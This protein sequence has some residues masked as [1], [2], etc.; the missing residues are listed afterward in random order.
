ML[1][2]APAP[3]VWLLVSSQSLSQAHLTGLTSEPLTS[4]VQAVSSSIAFCFMHYLTAPE[5]SVGEPMPV[6]SPI[7]VLREPKHVFEI[8]R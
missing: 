7:G 4:A 8:T 2:A 1:S 6:H 3:C 5:A